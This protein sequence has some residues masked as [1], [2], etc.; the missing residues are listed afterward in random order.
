MK[1]DVAIVIS[2]MLAA[3]SS[4]VGGARLRQAPSFGLYPARDSFAGPPAPVDL[5]S[6]RGAYRFRT[7]LRKGAAAGPNFAGTYTVVT[8]GCGTQCVNSAIIDARTG[9]IYAMGFPSVGAP[10]YRLDSRLFVV[11]DP[12]ECLSPKVHFPEYSVRYEWTGNR[13]RAIDSI[14]VVAPCP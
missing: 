7:V 8:W 10:K 2:F 9:R 3:V 12:G 1:L 11:D 14:R 6:A 4:E 5:K 13:L